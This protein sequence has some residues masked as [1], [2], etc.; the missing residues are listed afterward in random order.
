MDL[1]GI[2]G[3]ARRCRSERANQGPTINEKWNVI[4]LPGRLYSM[5]DRPYSVSSAA[6]ADCL[7]V[8]RVAGTSPACQVAGFPF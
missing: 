3:T 8:D 1:L 7:R 6:P 2:F 4:S 5:G